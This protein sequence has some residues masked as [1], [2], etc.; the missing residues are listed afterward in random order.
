M[1]EPVVVH[2]YVITSAN[3]IPDRDPVDWKFYGSQTGDDGSW[4]ELDVQTNVK[5]ADRFQT[6]V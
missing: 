4:I 6:N 5:F 3:D 1:T 2:N